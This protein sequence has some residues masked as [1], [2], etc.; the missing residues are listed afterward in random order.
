MLQLA[1]LAVVG[2][3]PWG[4]FCPAFTQSNY[5]KSDHVLLVGLAAKMAFSR[6]D[7][8]HFCPWGGGWWAATAT[9]LAL[10]GC[11]GASGARVV[12]G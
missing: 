7:R 9:P 8:V 4:L 12:V 1:S 3:T 2:L 5:I 10:V 11:R 6:Q